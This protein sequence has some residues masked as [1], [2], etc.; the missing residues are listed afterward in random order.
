MG[1]NS[2][3]SSDTKR[4]WTNCMSRT[5]KL[6]LVLTL[7]IQLVPLQ[8]FAAWDGSGSTSD[9]GAGQVSGS[10]SAYDDSLSGYRFSFYSVTELDRNC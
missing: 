9:T 7:L 2:S 3:S 1:K 4:G 10:F 6:L 5:F 8:I